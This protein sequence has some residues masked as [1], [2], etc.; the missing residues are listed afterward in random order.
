MRSVSG[1]GG[2]LLVL[3][4]TSASVY[5]N[6]EYGLFLGIPVIPGLRITR[7]TCETQD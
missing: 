2:L 3:G 7:R 5:P 4:F 6:G 1:M